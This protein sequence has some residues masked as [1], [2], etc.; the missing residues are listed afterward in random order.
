[1]ADELRDAPARGK[2]LKPA[3][4]ASAESAGA[5]GTH[6]SHMASVPAAQGPAAQQAPAA[7]AAA[8]KK[9]KLLYVVA[10]VLAVVAIAGGAY[11]LKVNA[12]LAREEERQANTDVPSQVDASED[13][14]QNP[15]DFNSL[16][17]ENPDIYAWITIPNTD[18]NLPILQ[19]TEDDL[20]YLDHD[21]DKNPS[22]AGALFSQSANS[23][24]FSDPVTVVYGHVM[25]GSNLFFHDLHNFEDADFFAQNK[26]FTV[27][28]PGHI[29]TYE[30]VAA[31]EYDNRH[32]LNSFDFSNA[33]TL[34]G[35]FD[36]VLNP[37]S[38]K[39]NVREGVTLTA[40]TDKILQLSTCVLSGDSSSVR[41][42]V[43]GVLRDDQPTR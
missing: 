4:S 25:A 22:A 36:S 13:L 10:G 20:F 40:G 37:S 39:R 42:I 9:S 15:V 34:Q 29:L 6:M 41:Y 11:V 3:A 17:V 43:T 14:P 30:V 1:M 26:E 2:H 5:H 21:Q 27:Y 19:S 32:I 24:D 8:K 16:K 12:D 33:T 7:P 35:Y 31:Y 18:V 28:T 38:L 23:T